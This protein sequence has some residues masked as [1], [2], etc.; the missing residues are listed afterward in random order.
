MT[1]TLQP[2]DVSYGP[3]KLS[4]DELWGAQ[5]E[6]LSIPRMRYGLLARMM[7]KPVDLLYGRQGSFTKFAMLEIIAR[8]PY[9]AWERMGYWAVQRHAGR[10]AVARRVFDRIVEARADQDNEQ[11]HLLIMQDFIQ[12][13][14]LKQGWLRHKLVP[15]FIAFFYYHMSWLLFLVRPELSYRLNAEFEDH[16]EHEYM[17]FVSEH[18]ELESM[19]DPGTY[20]DEYGRYSSVADLLRQIGHDERTHKLDGL[21]KADKA[22]VP[23]Q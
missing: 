4:S 20:A 7:F 13:Q 22:R 12:R 3:P 1:A 15:W 18:P 19:P 17:T 14:G 8:V 21:A 10:S 23:S 9:Q 16:A 11:W 6:T 5:Q 2:P